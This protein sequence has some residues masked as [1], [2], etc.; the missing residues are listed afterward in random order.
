MLKWSYN[1]G[2]CG[3]SFTTPNGILASPSYPENYP[4]DADCIFTISQPTSTVILLNFLI[5]DIEKAAW[6][7]CHDYIEIRDGPSD[8]PFLDRVCGN[9]IPAPIQSNQNLVWMRYK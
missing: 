9:K 5:I 4:D 2:A 1:H 8:A 3:G 6:S 7:Q